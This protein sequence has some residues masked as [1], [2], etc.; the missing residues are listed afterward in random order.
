MK[1]LL[2]EEIEVEYC[3]YGEVN[4]VVLDLLNNEKEYDKL[5][6]TDISV[7]ED[8]AEK[9]DE[10]S[11]KV[12]LLDHHST[13]LF[14][15]KYK[16]ASVKE[17]DIEGK[18]CATKLVYDYISDTYFNCKK[19]NN[20]LESF[21]W[22]TKLFDT[23]LW[24]DKY[25]DESAKQ[26]NDL[27]Y[28]LGKEDFVENMLTKISENKPLFDD[29]DMKLLE[30]KQREIDAFVEKKNKDLIIIDIIGYKAGV[31]F[32]ETNQSELGNR[33]STMNPD[34]DFI[35]MIGQNGI[36]YRTSKYNVNVAEIAKQL[37]GGGHPKA[38]G[39]PMSKE[40]LE[41][42]IYNLFKFN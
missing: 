34:L 17:Y 10:I 28:I 26:L 3:S 5:F 7:T 24:F 23:W 8:V 33:L 22:R 12:V 13:A 32:A 19:S 42:F 37:G 9:L 1:S 14:L 39:S 36:S 27:R 35:A 29:F 16:W 38:S 6:I 31:V 15:N 41:D 40:C 25:K 2:D 11:Y 20:T 21:V 18:T 4:D 30:L